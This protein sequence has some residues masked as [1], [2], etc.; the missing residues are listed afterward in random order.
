M[1]WLVSE[2]LVCFI[3]MSGLVPHYLNDV[4]FILHFNI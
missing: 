4:S 1:S 2:F 3:D